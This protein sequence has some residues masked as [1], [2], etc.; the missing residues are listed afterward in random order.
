MEKGYKSHQAANGDIYVVRGDRYAIPCDKCSGSGIY[1][2]QVQSASGPVAAQDVCYRCDGSQKEPKAKW[3][4]KQEVDSHAVKRQKAQ[5]K[6]EAKREAEWAAR[7]AKEPVEEPPAVEYRYVNAA[8]GDKIEIAGKVTAAVTIDGYYG[9][10]RLVVIETDGH[11]IVKTFT[12]AAWAYEVE[13]DQDIVIAATVKDFGYY[14]G[15]PETVV[16]RP[17]V[18]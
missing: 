8:V 12:S 16:N 6:R 18:V 3:I 2:R 9:P 11:E 13:R 4:T 5:E 17:K 10:S 15:Q 1:W 14:Q 7:A